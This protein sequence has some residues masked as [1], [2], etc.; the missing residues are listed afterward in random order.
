MT[1]LLMDITWIEVLFF[2]TSLFYAGFFSVSYQGGSFFQPGW[3]DKK[4]QQPSLIQTGI[5]PAVRR[6][7]TFIR[8][9]VPVLMDQSK[10]EEPSV[11]ISAA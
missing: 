6:A 8:R 5:R 1:E 4:Q 2:M 10:D 11:F 7:F 9:K 3:F